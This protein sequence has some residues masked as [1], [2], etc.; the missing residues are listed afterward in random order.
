MQSYYSVI[1]GC[2]KWQEVGGTETS[3]YNGYRILRYKD[4]KVPILFVPEIGGWRSSWNEDIE[5]LLAYIDQL[6]KP[7]ES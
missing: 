3:I 4:Y 2:L 1:A 5:S 7:P 6:A